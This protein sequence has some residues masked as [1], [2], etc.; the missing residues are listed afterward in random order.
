MVDRKSTSFKQEWWDE[1]S[2]Y[3]EEHP[4]EGFSPEDVK[5]FI[6]KIM[7]SY[8]AD[9]TI[10]TTEEEIKMLKDMKKLED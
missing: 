9:S 2:D 5:D 8:M 1:V 7:N 3:L 4:E 6:K 10:L